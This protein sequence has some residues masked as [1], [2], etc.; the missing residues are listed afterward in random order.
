ME[1][2]ILNKQK[3]HLLFLNV[4]GNYPDAPFTLVIWNDVRKQFKH[5]PGD[6][7]KGKA[8]CIYGK[9]I[10]Y[11]DKPEIVISNPSQIRIN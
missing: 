6:I 3:A 1:A 2:S 7:F 9:I 11:K 8:V 5:I 10:L 4:G